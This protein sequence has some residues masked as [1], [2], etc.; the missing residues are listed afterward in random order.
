M[1]GTFDN[2]LFCKTALEF[3]PSFSLQAVRCF[4]QVLVLDTFAVGPKLFPFCWKTCIFVAIL[5]HFHSVFCYGFLPG[6]SFG[7]STIQASLFCQL[8]RV[9][10][11][12]DGFPFRLRSISWLGHIIAI[13]LS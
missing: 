4:F 5:T 9:T 11:L 7:C 8:R 12:V 10:R 3:A 1:L 13:T 2:P 6:L